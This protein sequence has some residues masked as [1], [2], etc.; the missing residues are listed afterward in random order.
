ML[1]YYQVL[2]VRVILGLNIATNHPC[3][4][5]HAECAVIDASLLTSCELRASFRKNVI[6]FA[7]GPLDDALEQINVLLANPF[8]KVLHLITHGSPGVL[9]FEGSS[10]DISRID[11]VR[12]ACSSDLK[13][14]IWSCSVGQGE[15]GVSF[16]NSLAAVTK[17]RV[18][19]ASREIG[20]VNGRSSWTLDVASNLS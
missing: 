8:M 6:P 1:G 19:A 2:R 5:S 3:I 11:N 12:Q 18:Y 13:I 7:V 9:E 14:C 17:A 10:I 20:L 15:S 16:V 4:R